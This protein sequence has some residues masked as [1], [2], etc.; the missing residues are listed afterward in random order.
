MATHYGPHT[1]AK[2]PF[3]IVPEDLL[4]A[5]ASIAHCVVCVTSGNER[6]ESLREDFR[7]IAYMTIL[8][9]G[10]NY[11]PGHPSGASFITSIKSKVC[12]RLWSERRKEARYIPFSH[13][14]ASSDDELLEHNPLVTRLIAD[15]CAC[16]S[17]D[18]AVVRKIEA[19][20]LHALLSQM[21]T[22]LSEKERK[23]LKLKYFKDYTGVEIAKALGMSEGRVSQLTSTALT[24]LKKAYL[25]MQD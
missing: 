18:C 13:A 19:E 9:E 3:Y 20:Q 24:K 23:V 11:D 16:E 4:S 21:S 2:C 14:E 7:Q 8:E 5:E 22:R 1:C 10:P 6:L 17:V 15:A 12:S 25:R